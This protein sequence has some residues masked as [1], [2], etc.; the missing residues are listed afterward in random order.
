LAI[1]VILNESTISL[2]VES[3]EGTFVAPAAGT[4]YIES[5]S[6]GL[7]M[8]KTIEEI[9]RDVLGGTVEKEASRRGIPEVTGT[10]PVEL[11][12]RQRLEQLRKH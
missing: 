10:V 6:D 1:G 7:E 5:L 3:T 9:E 8:T 12:H 2:M 11:E 4:D